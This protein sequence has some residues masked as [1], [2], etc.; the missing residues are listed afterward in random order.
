MYAFLTFIALL[1]VPGQAPTARTWDVDGVKREAP[2][3]APSKKAAE[4]LP[5]VFDFHGHGGTA[6]HAARTHH[7]QET[8]PEA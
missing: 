2:V 7:F 5:L 1:F 3:F 6:R 4:K 8:W